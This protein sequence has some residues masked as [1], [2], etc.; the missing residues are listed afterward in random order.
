VNPGVELDQTFQDFA[1]IPD[2]SRE[3][4]PSVIDASREDWIDEWTDIVIG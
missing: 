3:L 4:E 2:E 1:V